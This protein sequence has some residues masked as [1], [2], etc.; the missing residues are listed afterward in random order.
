MASLDRLRRAFSLS[1]Y[2]LFVSVIL[3]LVSR[4]GHAQAKVVWTDQ[5]KPIVEQLR[6]LRGLADEQRAAP[7]KQLALQIRDLPPGNHKVSLAH[8]LASLATEGD[9]GHDTLQLVT[10]TLERSLYEQPV[11]EKGNEPA[12]PYVE[13]AELVRYEHTQAFVGRSS[14]CRCACQASSRRSEATAC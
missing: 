10:T 7:T 13:L 11:Q 3:L 14:V 12:P 9:F 1:S 6:G 4:S 2:F 5:E 8:S